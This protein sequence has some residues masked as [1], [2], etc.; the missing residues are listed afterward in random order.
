MPASEMQIASELIALR[1]ENR[2]LRYQVEDDAD[3]RDLARVHRLIDRTY[4]DAQCLL[5]AHFAWQETQRATA[6]LSHRRWTYAV[7]M[8]KLGRLADHRAR[9]L[10]ITASDPGRAAVKLAKA[11]DTAMADPSS[12]RAMLPVSRRPGRLR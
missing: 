5:A 10:R 11:R 3:A 8:L 12:L 1:R 7:A 2:R 9:Y 4:Y 6:P